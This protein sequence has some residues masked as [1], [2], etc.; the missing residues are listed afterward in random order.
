MVITN[1]LE[2][3]SNVEKYLTLEELSRDLLH[4]HTF[5]VKTLIGKYLQAY[6]HAMDE[7]NLTQHQAVNMAKRAIL[8]Y[9]M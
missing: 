1:Q 3:T 7:Q 8:D 5:W 2:R 4:G 6:D 9:Q